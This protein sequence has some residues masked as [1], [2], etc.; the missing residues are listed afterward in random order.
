MF[1]EA[2]SCLLFKLCSDQSQVWFSC[3]FFPNCVVLDCR[4]GLVEVFF[5][6]CDV[7][8]YLSHYSIAVSDCRVMMYG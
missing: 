2:L 4:S 3:V 6:C 7:F 5:F 8:M 1:D